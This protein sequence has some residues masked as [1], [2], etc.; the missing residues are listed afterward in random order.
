[1]EAVKSPGWAKVLLQV[2]GQK[3]LRQIVD[4]GRLNRSQVRRHVRAGIAEG[5]VEILC[6]AQVVFES[7]AVAV[8]PEARLAP[9]TI[10]GSGAGSEWRRD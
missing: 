8:G 1:M 9:G 6:R 7:P 4:V 5:I 2:D 10:F 3:T